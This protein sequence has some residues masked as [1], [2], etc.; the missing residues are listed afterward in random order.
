MATLDRAQGQQLLPERFPRPFRAHAMPK[1][2]RCAVCS[3]ACSLARGPP[4]Y[5][6]PPAH[7]LCAQMH[8]AVWCSPSHLSKSLNQASH[9]Q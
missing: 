5:P 8:H 1:D 9:K 3:R 6:R 4:G 2:A 7:A